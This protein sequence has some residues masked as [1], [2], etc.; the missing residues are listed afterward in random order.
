[1]LILSV[2]AVASRFSNDPAV[3]HTPRYQAGKPFAAEATRLVLANFDNPNM[4]ILTSLLL[5]GLHEFGTM[6]GGKSWSFGGMA[7]RMA[8]ALSLHKEL[9]ETYP[10]G[11]FHGPT[12][13]SHASYF[14][15]LNKELRRRVMWACFSMDRFNSSGT[16]RLGMIIESD[17]EIQ[18][19]MS[20]RDLELAIEE[21]V[22]ERLDGT[23]AGDVKNAKD[24]M[25]VAAYMVRA[26]AL[27]G[28]V[29]KYLNLV[30]YPETATFEYIL[31][32]FQGRKRQRQQAAIRSHVSVCSTESTNSGLSTNPSSKTTVHRGKL[33][34][35]CGNWNSK[36]V[37]VHPH[38]ISS[39]PAFHEP[40]CLTY[41]P[42]GP[43]E[44]WG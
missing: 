6:Q 42:S 10:Q 26:I 4:T 30:C 12:G 24:N 44:N 39:C 22:T 17:I 13:E 25:G 40:V 33:A 5:L 11:S 2:C 27:F 32:I 14:S 15:I 43:S 20:D 31:T 7:T 37:H 18:L 38:C 41:A 23:V 34:K 36:S 3:Q 8:Y 29:S 28:R 16:Q 35:P 19:P 9:E 1:M 21:K